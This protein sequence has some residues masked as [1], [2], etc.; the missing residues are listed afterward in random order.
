MG[1]VLTTR[2]VGVLYGVPA[3]LVDQVVDSMDPS[4]GWFGLNRMVPRE[5]L[6]SVATE[7][8]KRLLADSAEVPADD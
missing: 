6:Q 2:E 1:E 4:F 3:E 5:R 8:E 7:I